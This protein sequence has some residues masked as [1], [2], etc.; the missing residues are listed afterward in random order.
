MIHDSRKTSRSSFVL[1]KENNSAWRTILEQHFFCSWD[2]D[3]LFSR[4]ESKSG[5]LLWEVLEDIKYFELL[6][7]QKSEK[8]D[9]AP[10]S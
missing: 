7:K 8:C 10:G 1:K 4:S 6:C 3:L 5:V 9:G 2:D